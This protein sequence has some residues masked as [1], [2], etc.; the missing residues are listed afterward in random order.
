MRVPQCPAA[1]WCMLQRG[2]RHV[3]TPQSC[4]PVAACC[5]ER[6]QACL[7]ALVAEVHAAAAEV[8]RGPLAA[9]QA[10]P[11]QEVLAVPLRSK[12]PS[13]ETTFNPLYAAAHCDHAASHA[14]SHAARD[15]KGGIQSCA[16]GIWGPL[17]ARGEWHG[18]NGRWKGRQRERTV[19]HLP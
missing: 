10:L 14:A 11:Q 4:G 2:S 15:V 16:N 6:Q 13:A 7:V 3:A 9:E 19:Q 12:P 8:R 5:S 17:M 18:V 1:R